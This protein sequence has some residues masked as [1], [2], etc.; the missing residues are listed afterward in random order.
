MVSIRE[1][2]LLILWHPFP[3]LIVAA[4]LSHWDSNPQQLTLAWNRV[5]L[6]LLVL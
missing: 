1:H 2:W 3:L 4:I 6:G 5:H